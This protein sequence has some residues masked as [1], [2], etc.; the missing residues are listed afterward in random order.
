MPSLHSRANKLRERVLLSQMSIKPIGIA[1]IAGITGTLI[2][3]TNANGLNVAYAWD[4]LEILYVEYQIPLALILGHPATAADL[5]KPLGLGLVAGA[6]ESNYEHHGGNNSNP[7]LGNSG[8]VGG[9]QG[10][11]GGRQGG[12]TGQGTTMNGSAYDPNKAEQKTWLKL[13]LESG[14]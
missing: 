14:K 4:S 9:R 8:S 6:I 10:G 11:I 12:V 3:L 5:Q 2:P 1:G 7:G 13:H